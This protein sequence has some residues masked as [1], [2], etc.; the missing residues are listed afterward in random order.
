MG[1]L[2]LYLKI[3]NNLV[4][5]RIPGRA[6]WLY[7]KFSDRINFLLAQIREGEKKFGRVPDTSLFKE[8]QG[9]EKMAE[10]IQEIL[11]KIEQPQNPNAGGEN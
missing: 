4:V 3:L 10:Q 9:N 2:F 5:K 1:M 8:K 6:W 7:L 11:T